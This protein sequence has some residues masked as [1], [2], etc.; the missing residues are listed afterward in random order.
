MLISFSIRKQFHDKVLCELV[1]MDACHLLLRRPW[2]Y[3]RSSIH[4]GRRNIYS[5]TKEGQRYTL[6]PMKKIAKSLNPNSRLVNKSF[7]K[8]SM[9]L[10]IFYMLLSAMEVDSMP[11]PT[12]IK[13]LMTQ[14]G[15]VFPNELPND[16]P[17][18]RDIQHCID[19]VTGSSLPNKP[20]Y[21]KTPLERDELQKQV[22]E[23][24]QKGYIRP[25]ISPCSVLALLKKDGSRRMCVDS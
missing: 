1:K 22:N 16:L 7:V 18:M 2:Q 3:N 8:E 25:S 19:L 10:G 11:I 17:P 14:F 13:H 23:L 21:R 24:L 4:D 5:I 15:D 9:D 6:L 12:E 20:A